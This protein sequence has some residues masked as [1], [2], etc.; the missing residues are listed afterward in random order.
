M[1]TSS[2]S[3]ASLVA[4]PT[5][6]GVSKFASSLQQVLSRAVGIASLPLDSLQAGLT[7][8]NNKQ[9]AVQ[10]LDSTFLGLQ[11]AITS[12]QTAVSSTLLN[13]SI[14]T[15]GIVTAAVQKGASAGNYSIEVTDLGSYSNAL[16][17]AGTSPVTNTATSGIAAAGPLT[18][19]VGGVNTIV[20]PASTSLSDLAAAIN[21]QA[22]SQVQANIVNV[23]STGAPDY[24]LSLTAANLGTAALD[25]T[26]STG[27]DLIS[28]SSGGSLASYLVD[29]SSTPID[30]TTR[31]ITLAPGLTVNL[32]G[33]SASG[34]PTTITVAD[35]AGGL[36]SAFS[37]FAA[38]YNAAVTSVGQHY[39]QSG[40]PLAGDS[41]I[42]NLSSVLNQLGTYSNGTPAS[43][44]ANYGITLDQTGQLSVDTAKFTATANANFPGI[45]SAI[46][47]TTTGGFL[48]TANN[49]LTGLE[50]PTTG[51]IKTEET[52]LS[53][54]ITDQNTKISN[55][56]AT[57]NQLQTNLTAEISKADAAI[58][59]LE[60]Q[61]S[62]V[63][64]LFAQY[65]GASNTQNNGLA[66]L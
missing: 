36:A 52:D 22:G 7:D 8:L 56:Q 59:S 16:S 48:Q 1:S 45:L 55:E 64:G 43:A 17:V 66:T 15:A 47:T 46:G 13:S 53:Q 4:P 12:L 11:Q 18:L 42:Q 33:Q 2:T 37:S 32:V 40:S 58:A 6:T 29:G 28:S 19:S 35:D 30:S 25:L 24:R 50:D 41:L 65:T 63:T 62:Y 39:G 38:S 23:G 26:D 49:L 60:S 27:A 21:S 9:A 61:V 54:Q 34:Q 44:L 5:F 51:V 20:T 10:S 31:A 57:V 14:S 3:L